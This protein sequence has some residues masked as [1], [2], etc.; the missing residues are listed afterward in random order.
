MREIISTKLIVLLLFVFSMSFNAF[1]QF[2]ECNTGVT[3]NLNCV[4]SLNGGNLAFACGDSG[5]VIKSTTVGSIWVNV[6]GNGIPSNAN[7]FNIFAVDNNVVLTAGNIGTNTYVYRTSS[8]GSNWSQVFVQSN[9][10]INAMNFR[11]VLTGII[12]GNP[13]AGRWS[14]WKTSNGGIN[15]DS[16]GMFLPQS[17]GETGFN[18]S[19]YGKNMNIRFGTNNSRIYYSTNY[20][21]T[22]II[23]STSPEVNS[24]AVWF[25]AHDSTYGNLGGDS[26]L[27][28]TNSGSN[29]EFIH[30]SAGSGKISGFTWGNFY[31][32]SSFPPSIQ[33]YVRND[34]KIYV[35]GG[36]NIVPIY[37]APSGVYRYL[38]DHFNFGETVYAVRSN[39]GIT[40]FSTYIVSVQQISTEIPERWLLSQ[41]YPNPFNP[42]TH[43]GFRIAESG[44]VRVTVFDALGK[45]IQT[46]VNQE[47]QPGT[48]DV[49]F[50]GTDMPSGVYYYKIESGSFAETKKM[51]LIK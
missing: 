50:N 42:N 4:S 24:T 40:K 33:W 12:C 47:L 44:L 39:G 35:F 31:V 26:L 11:N 23:Q 15:W 5:T 25:Y 20:G 10:R 34:N 46:L 18:N 2:I 7:L 36:G 13:V 37:I 41:N 49:D 32:E 9:G 28:T 19:L 14:M 1:S 6:T 38:S 43:I 48:Y 16:T 30:P 8:G 21:L 27:K 22:W 3:V 51:V 29:W 45:E 17:G